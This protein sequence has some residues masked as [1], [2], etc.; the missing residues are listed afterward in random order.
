MSKEL[1]PNQYEEAVKAIYDE[2]QQAAT[3]LLKEKADK[4]YL[5]FSDWECEIS[6][7]YENG[8]C[9]VSIF[10][11]GINEAGK[12][13]VAAVVDD[14]GYGHGPDDFPQAWTEATKL[15]PDCYPSLYWFVAK[16]I[17]KTITKVEADEIAKEYWYDE[18]DDF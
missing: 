8:G 4:C 11:V 9:S 18:D 5:A 14:I 7:Y 15:K 10:G 16:N 13:C 2:A 1:N 12:L 3:N 6:A 17:Y